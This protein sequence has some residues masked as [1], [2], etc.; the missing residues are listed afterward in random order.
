MKRRIEQSVLGLLTS[1][2]SIRRFRKSTISEEVL[3]MIVEAGQSAP[4]YFQAYSVIWIKSNELLE[5]TFDICGTEAI[6][7]AAAVLLV[8]LDFNKL[9]KYAESV[10]QEHFLKMDVYP[11][12]A[13]LSIFET[14]LMVEN[15]VTASE[16]LGYG[17][18]LL[19]CGMYE[20][21]KFVEMLKLPHGVVPIAVLLI[22]E[23]DESPPPRPRW[24]I[25]NVLH[26]DGY[27]PITREEIQKY[28]EYADK[29]L[30]AEGYLLKYANFKGSY[31]EYLTERLS[32]NKELK[33]SY[34]ALSSFLRRH[35]L[36]I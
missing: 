18:L 13:L 20:C 12:E 21:E 29:T 28:L 24:P 4:C 25:H 14:G 6:R 35:G 32:A 8:C 11:A 30:A 33:Q 7:Q 34:N 10:T 17:T 5:N 3:Q 9:E 23:K 22:G 27:N 19:D 26:I 2:R 1:R 31:V 36:K 15:M 16:A